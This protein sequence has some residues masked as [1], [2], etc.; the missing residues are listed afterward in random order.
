MPRK[1]KTIIEFISAGSLQSLQEAACANDP[2]V[3]LAQNWGST[4]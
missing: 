2:P 3:L 4:C 1:V